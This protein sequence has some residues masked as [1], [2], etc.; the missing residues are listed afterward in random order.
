M[1]VLVTGASG[2]VGRFLLARLIADGHQ[3]TVLGRRPVAGFSAGF[4][5]YDL[6][7]LH[8]VLPAAD[9]LVHCALLHEPGRFRG[10]EG[11]DPERF[12]RVN[13]DGTAGLFRAAKRTGCRQAVFLSSRA[14]YGDHR[15]GEVLVE[16]DAPRPDSLY[17]EVK[18]AGER[19]LDGLCVEGFSGTVLRATGIYGLP[20]GQTTHKW[21]SLFDAFKREEPIPARRATE[22]HGED[23]SAAVSLLLTRSGHAPFSVFNVSDLLLDRRELLA[24][25]AEISGVSG[26]LPEEAET[27]PGV[28]STDRL[29]ALGWKPGGTSR[30]RA[31]LQDSAR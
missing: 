11:D 23:L 4:C 20:S 17:G 27:T 9:A 21:S 29:R 6:A 22:V 25:Y 14:V 13:V 15:H 28:M 2:T 5:H 12:I 24:L 8:P 19:T 1:H 7:D 16:T 31:F 30:L 18:L 3:V 26:K 10:G